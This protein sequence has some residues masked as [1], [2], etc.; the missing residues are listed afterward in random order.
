MAAFNMYTYKYSVIKYSPD[1]LRGET[2]NIGL[3]IF[4]DTKV[5]V[6]LLQ[7]SAKARI[8]DGS[9]NIDDI[10]R[11][12]DSI[13]GIVNWSK[14]IDE[15]VAY[16]K[17]FGKAATWLS[18]PSAF[19]ID[20]VNQYDKRVDNLFNTLVKP[21][22]TREPSQTRSRFQTQIKNKFDALGILGKDTDDLSRHKVVANYPISDKTGFTAD[23]IL[24]N[25]SFHITE[26]ID[27]NVHDVN[28]KF[29]ETSMKV[30]AIMEGK[31]HL[32]KKTCGYFV[33]TA[34]P[35]KE[36]EIVSHLNLAEEYSDK[37][38]NFSSKEEKTAYFNMIQDLAGVNRLLH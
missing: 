17:S 16:L 24:K 36:K 22:S 35:Q 9:S 34:T 31:K 33:Y 12:K 30:M 11:L 32:E 8:L 25:G 5:D 18:E 15:A 13:E 7:S 3:V 26:T 23:F 38:Y 20:D 28:A 19:I 4:T 14:N 1:P 37:M 27:F 6:R 21:Y 10:L 29:K 2:L